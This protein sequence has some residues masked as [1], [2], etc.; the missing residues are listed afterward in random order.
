MARNDIQIAPAHLDHPLIEALDE[1]RL[2]QSKRNGTFCMLLNAGT[3]H[4]GISR[5]SRESAHPF[6]G[7][8]ANRKMQD[9]KFRVEDIEPV[10]RDVAD[11]IIDQ[12]LRKYQLYEKSSTLL[13]FSEMKVVRPGACY[14]L[15]TDVREL[16]FGTS[17]KNAA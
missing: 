17:F 14:E 8:Y 15:I 3:V 5:L 7:S 9:T 13:E 1:E 4:A 11:V 16:E 2:R 10:I 12:G 6:F